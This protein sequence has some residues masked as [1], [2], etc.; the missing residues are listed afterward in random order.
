MFAR[1]EEGAEGATR[2]A[3]LIISIRRKY[4]AA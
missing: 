4:A 2:R 3:L 1:K